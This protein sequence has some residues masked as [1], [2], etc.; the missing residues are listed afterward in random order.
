MTHDAILDIVDSDLLQFL[1]PLELAVLLHYIARA[2]TDGI[3]W[4]SSVSI[5]GKLGHRGGNHV[6]AARAR[7][8]DRGLLKRL[9]LN[10]RKAP[11]QVTLAG[12]RKASRN[13]TSP[14]LGLVP[15]PVPTSPESGRATS[16][17]SGHRTNP[18]NQSKNQSKKKGAAEP[19]PPLPES[20]DVPS[21]RGAWSEWLKFREATRK[22]FTANAAKD[23]FARL[24]RLKYP[25]DAA[26]DLV[27]YAIAQK[28]SGFIFPNSKEFKHD[29]TSK[30]AA[31][32]R[33]EY[34]EPE[35]II[36]VFRAEAG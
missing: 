2:N 29:R 33:G 21:F 8:I 36:P 16:P 10:G 18:K 1:T 12:N 35:H 27:R 28:W 5:A 17:E 3:S 34:D 19:L 31:T 6:R 32:D 13:G 14:N 4:P 22:P 15:N 7:L 20:L 11:Y 9:P 25:P 26:A 23:A 30:P 24:A